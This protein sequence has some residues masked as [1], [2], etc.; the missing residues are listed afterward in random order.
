[1]QSQRRQHSDDFVQLNRWF[2]M[3][4][5]ID[6]SLRHAREVGQF[7][8]PQAE[9]PSAQSY[10]VRK[11]SARVKIGHSGAPITIRTSVRASVL[12]TSQSTAWAT[13]PHDRTATGGHLASRLGL[14]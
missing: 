13:K 6:E 12:A 11:G 2:A 7:A 3:L 1:M 9:L 14:G 10:R 4:Q 5:C 8:L